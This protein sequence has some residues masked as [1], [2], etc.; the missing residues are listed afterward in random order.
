M[1]PVR[2]D[3]LLCQDIISRIICRAECDNMFDIRMSG[4]VVHIPSIAFVTAAGIWAGET[5]IRICLDIT[6]G[7]PVRICN[8]DLRRIG[9][10]VVLISTVAPAG[11]SMTSGAN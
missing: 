7:I 1:N 9:C 5:V 4:T 2:S 10:Q 11:N 8:N 6:A 3:N